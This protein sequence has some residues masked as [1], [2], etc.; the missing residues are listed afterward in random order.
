MVTR[1]GGLARGQGSGSGSWRERG[2]GAKGG[3][4]TGSLRIQKM[5][6][7]GVKLSL[8]RITISL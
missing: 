3:M 4:V 6:G 2:E 1:G 5:K 8:E 7:W